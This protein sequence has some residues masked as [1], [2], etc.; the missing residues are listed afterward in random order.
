[1]PVVHL[2]TKHGIWERLYDTALHLDGSDFLCQDKLLKFKGLT[3]TL[4]DQAG[5][6]T[7]NGR[8]DRCR[9][10]RVGVTATD[11]IL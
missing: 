11:G 6:Q 10:L 4:T 9:S 1:M 5:Y 3:L 7:L 2:D 8:V